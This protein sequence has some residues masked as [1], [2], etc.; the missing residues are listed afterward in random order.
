MLNHPRK[1]RYCK[2]CGRRISKQNKTGFCQV[3][4]RDRWK[5]PKIEFEAPIKVVM[6]DG[7]KVLL[8]GLQHKNEGLNASYSDN[9]QKKER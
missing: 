8:G 5:N 2:D 6:I 9:P 3:C 7:K 4:K 1:P